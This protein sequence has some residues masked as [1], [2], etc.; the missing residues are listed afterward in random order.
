MEQIVDEHIRTIEERVKHQAVVSYMNGHVMATRLMGEETSFEIVHE[1]AVR[2]L[3][4]YDTGFLI[5]QSAEIKRAVREIVS[6]GVGRV[7]RASAAEMSQQ[8]AKTFEGRKW[9]YDRIA[10][11]EPANAD[12]EGGLD[13]Y[14]RAGHDWF[15]RIL[16]G[17]PCDE[18]VAHA[19]NNPHPR[20]ECYS[21]H[22]SE[23]C[24]FTVAERR[25]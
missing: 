18:C 10:R 5:R 25:R 15:D 2:W 24:D 23:T 6:E 22:P 17:K 12:I 13:R 11:S 8:I 9:E 7:P 16:G 14:Q 1:D 19:A 4:Q 3:R 20:A 21:L